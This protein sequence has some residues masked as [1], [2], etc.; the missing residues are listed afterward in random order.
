ML[1]WDSIAGLWRREPRRCA[2]QHSTTGKYGVFSQRTTGLRG[3][4]GTGMFAL[5]LSLDKQVGSR[6]VKGKRWLLLTR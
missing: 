4:L 6:L 3:S 5:L 1:R 2:P